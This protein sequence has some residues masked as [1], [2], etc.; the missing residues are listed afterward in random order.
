MSTTTPEP[1]RDRDDLDDFF[2]AARAA[3][4]EPADDLLARI[5]MDAETEQA[6]RRRPMRPVSRLRSLFA[7]W[8]GL[9][10]LRGAA[11]AATLVA[12]IW[13]GAAPPAPLSATVDGIWSAGDAQIAGSVDPMTA[14]DLAW[15]GE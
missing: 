5:A 9:P 3:P 6:A 8:V 15:M 1:R 13:I 7:G 12:G 11:L 2:A 14:Y 10:A 4:P